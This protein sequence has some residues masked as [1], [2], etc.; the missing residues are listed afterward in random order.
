MG[1]AE[2]RM[3]RLITGPC[4]TNKFL[5]FKMIW[6]ISSQ[7]LKPVNVLILHL[8][9]ALGT[10]HKKLSRVAKTLTVSGINGFWSLDFLGS[11]PLPNGRQVV[12]YSNRR[13]LASGQF[14]CAHSAGTH[15]WDLKMESMAEKDPSNPVVPRKRRKCYG[16]PGMWYATAIC[17]MI[18]TATYNLK[19]WQGYIT[20]GT[21]W[22]PD[23]CGVC[24]R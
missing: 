9:S 13:Q 3:R 23:C 17:L 14:G 8:P 16:G 12:N 11:R 20:R 24:R 1:C 7:V 15:D 5:A 22:W 19:R 18:L 6:E 10:A 2:T 21:S 4:V